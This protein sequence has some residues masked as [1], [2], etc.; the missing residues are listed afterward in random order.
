MT[1]MPGVD[2]G[3]VDEG[4]ELVQKIEGEIRFFREQMTRISSAL[5]SLGRGRKGKSRQDGLDETL[6]VQ[7]D[8][9]A[10]DDRHLSIGDLPS[11][12]AQPDVLP[13]LGKEGIAQRRRREDEI[14]I[15]HPCPSWPVW[16]PSSRP[17]SWL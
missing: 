10:G 9:I 8:D 12:A 7:G 15:P 1:T 6:S 13:V 5:A 11:L 3:M 14:P 4:E 17:S 2:P 16:R